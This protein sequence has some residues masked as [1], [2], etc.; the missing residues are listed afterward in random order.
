MEFETSDKRWKYI[1]IVLSIIQ[2]T[3]FSAAFMILMYYSITTSNEANSY[4][5]SFREVALVSV[6]LFI[7][8]V[9][10]IPIKKAPRNIALS[11]I[12]FYT[13]YLLTIM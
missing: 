5:C 10:M 8:L 6:A 4:L 1:N 3:C 13:P 12:K 11:Q 9:R 7:K 2:M